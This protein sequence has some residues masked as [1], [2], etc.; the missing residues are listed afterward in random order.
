MTLSIKK[1]FG[2]LSLILLCFIGGLIASPFLFP[3]TNQQITKEIRKSYNYKFINPLLECESSTISQDKNLSSLKKSI[4]FIINQEIDNDQISFASIYYRDLNNGPW[5]G[6]NEKEYFSPAS[7]IKVPVMMAYLKETENNPS[8]LDEKIVNTKN[9]DY[10]QQ[11][12]T[13]TQ[14]LELDKEYTIGDL[15][16]RMII[17]SDNAAYELL[18]ENIDNIKI[19]N[20]YKDLDVDISK[21]EKDPNGNIITVKDYSS[22][23]RILFNS[24]YLDRDNSEKAL[25]ILSKTQYYKGLVAGI[26][27]NITI[28]HKFGE[29][30]Y[31][32]SKE[33]QLHDCGIVY[34]P[35][36]PYLIC[37]MSRSTDF[38]KAANFIKQVSKVVYN[39]VSQ[40][41]N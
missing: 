39:H 28:A 7:L 31:L 41:Q 14:T 33:K 8:L 9:F 24:S 11:N 20:V 5:L 36:K 21:A 32:P 1:T 6:I 10:S 27:E 22:F 19:Y 25:N 16:N 15:I 2:I 38:D 34:L 3:K 30:Q 23:F 40:N 35:G 18:L 37:I 17:Y 12:V 4:Q 13:P 26:P 29:R